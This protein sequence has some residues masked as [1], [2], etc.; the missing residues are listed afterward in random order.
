MVVL[1]GGPFLMSEVP[2]YARISGQDGRE[3]VG[4]RHDETP[5]RDFLSP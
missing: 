4:E 3:V 5:S 2:L 1:E